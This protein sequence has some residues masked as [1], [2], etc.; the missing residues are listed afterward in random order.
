MEMWAQEVD[1][2]SDMCISVMLLPFVGQAEHCER[3][4]YNSML[5]P[6]S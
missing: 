6:N 4:I 3:V 5:F 1:L 2:S